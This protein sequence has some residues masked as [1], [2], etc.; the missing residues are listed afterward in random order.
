MRNQWDEQHSSN[1]M[2]ANIEDHNFF[3]KNF[4]QKGKQHIEMIRKQ[5][6]SKHEKNNQVMDGCYKQPF[7]HSLNS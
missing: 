3:H 2:V 5:R 6:H 1:G 4:K 7:F